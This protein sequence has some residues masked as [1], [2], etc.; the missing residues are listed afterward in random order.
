V[1]QESAKDRLAILSVCSRV[2]DVLMP[3]LIDDLAGHDIHLGI[4]EV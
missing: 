3:H 1:I 4:G 2:E